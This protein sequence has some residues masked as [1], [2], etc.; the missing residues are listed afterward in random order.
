MINRDFIH[1]CGEEFYV[2]TR[3]RDTIRLNVY[4]T[5]TG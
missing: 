1:I 5:A 4:V 2:E 3:K